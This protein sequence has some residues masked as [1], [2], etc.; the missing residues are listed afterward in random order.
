M[1]LRATVRRGRWLRT[2]PEA[3][4]LKSTPAMYD[5]GTRGSRRHSI[6]EWLTRDG[7]RIAVAIGLLACCGFEGLSASTTPGAR[8]LTLH[9][10]ARAVR[11]LSLIH[12]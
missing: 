8:G 6:P 12:I 11:H 7:V 3:V 5:R 1:K 9:R 10:T 2:G 4:M